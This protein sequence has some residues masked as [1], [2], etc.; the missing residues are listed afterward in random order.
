MIHAP[1]A[2]RPVQRVACGEDRA[3]VRAV[4]AH[5]RPRA[6]PDRREARRAAVARRL[7]P[8]GD[9]AHG[10]ADGRERL[11]RRKAARRF[12]ARQHDVDA[13]PV[14]EPPRLGRRLRRGVGDGLGV[15]VAA[16]AVLLAQ[17]PR[18]AHDPLHRV[19]GRAD[20]AR[21]QE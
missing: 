3:V 18:H 11:L 12:L 17:P 14:G 2:V 20:D 7:D 10:G 1:Q 21:R 19:L 13:K 8:R 6:L 9:A 5:D 4:G 15:D 16:E